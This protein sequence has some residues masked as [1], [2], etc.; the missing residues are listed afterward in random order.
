MACNLL[1]F[2]DPEIALIGE[3]RFF[4][5]LAIF[6]EDSTTLKALTYK[7]FMQQSEQIFEF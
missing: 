6:L 2:N 7:P 4:D 5:S 1:I 3:E